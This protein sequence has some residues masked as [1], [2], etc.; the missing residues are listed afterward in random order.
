MVFFDL[1]NAFGSVL[2]QRLFQMMTRL[3]VP[4]DFV[5]L[6][7]AFYE[8]SST[9]YRCKDGLTGEI[10]QQVGVKQGCPLSPILFNL[11]LQGLLSG[12]DHD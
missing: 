6:C 11:F 8:G 5:S 10:P 3:G 1:Q 12:L 7:S 9:R 2:H 4:P